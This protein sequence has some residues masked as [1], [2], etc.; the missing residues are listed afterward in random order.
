LQPLKSAIKPKLQKEC[1]SQRTRQC[2]LI[3]LGAIFTSNKMR[4][5]LFFHKKHLVGNYFALKKNKNIDFAFYFLYKFS[6]PCLPRWGG[7][8]AHRQAGFGEY[9]RRIET[10]VR[11]SVTTKRHRSAAYCRR[12]K[13]LNIQHG[14]SNDEGKAAKTGSGHGP[15]LEIG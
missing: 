2:N 8:H 15:P 4:N 6:K 10:V 13:G 12:V 14:I 3:V 1:A 11:Q 7:R 9:L 5:S